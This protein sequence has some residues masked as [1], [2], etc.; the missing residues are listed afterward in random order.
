MN[1]EVREFVC[2][3]CRM[4]SAEVGPITGLCIVSDPEKCPPGYELIYR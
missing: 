4:S 2:V 1:L 3:H